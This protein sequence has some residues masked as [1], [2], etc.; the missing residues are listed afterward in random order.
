MPTCRISG[1]RVNNCERRDRTSTPFAETKKVSYTKIISFIYQR[2]ISLIKELDI[3]YII[4]VVITKYVFKQ[5]K[6]RN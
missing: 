1:T 3:F 2:H 5:H 4:H 6:E